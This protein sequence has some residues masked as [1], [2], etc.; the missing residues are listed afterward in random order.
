MPLIDTLRADLEVDMPGVR[1]S[2]KGAALLLSRLAFSARLQA[3][4]LLRISH[5]LGR[6]SALLAAVVKWVNHVVTG[7]DAAPQARIGP[8]LALWHPSGVVIGPD[9]RIGARCTFMQGVTLGAGK[10]GSPTVGDDVF[11]GAG[12]TLYGAITVGSRSNIGAR[13]VVDMDVPDDA[14]VVGGRGRIVSVAG[15]RVDTAA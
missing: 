8:G 5:A 10:G 13:A 14:F 7:C 6:R 1:P 15:E 3:V 11:L 9:V 4:V 2:P 12:A